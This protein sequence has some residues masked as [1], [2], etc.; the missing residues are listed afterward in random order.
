MVLGHT[1]ARDAT[2]GLRPGNGVTGRE[3]AASSARRLAPVF[4]LAAA[5]F[6]AGRLAL[7]LAIPPGYAT[8]VWPPAGIAL[9]GLLIVGRRAW[10]GVLLG[11]FL[12]NVWTGFDPTSPLTTVVSVAVPA[13]L[14]LGAALQAVV[15]ASLVRRVVGTPVTLVHAGDVI[16]FLSVAGPISCLVGASVGVT[17]LSVTGVVDW[18]N[19]LVNWS[20]W[21]AGDTIGALVFAPFVVLWSPQARVVP[22]RRLLVSLP[23][24]LA[25]AS[26]VAL[27]VQV[28][29]VE[30]A[31]IENAIAGRSMAVTQVIQ[32]DVDRSVEILYSIRSLYGSSVEVNQHEFGTFAGALLERDP[33]IL[34]LSWDRRVRLDERAGIETSAQTDT[35]GFQFTE[36]EADGRRVQAGVR[37]E[38]VPVTFIEPLIAN[39]EVLGFDVASDPA[40]LAALSKARDTGQEMASGATM[41]VQNGGN[42]R[43]FVVFLP[44]YANGRP[45]GSVEERRQNLVG[46]TAG[47]F[48][49]DGLIGA[50]I[51][52]ADRTELVIR[53]YDGAVIDQ[54]SLVYAAGSADPVDRAP[55]WVTSTINVAGRT[56]TVAVSPTS[57][58]LGAQP[59]GQPWFVLVGGLLLV[60]L[61]GA[62][63][64]I[65]TGR[66]DAI[67]NLVT[68]RTTQLSEANMALEREAG[69]RVRVEIA[70]RQMAS[71]VESSTDA[72]VG[73]G[74]DWAIVTWNASAT[75]LYGYTADE[76]AGRS[77][78]ILLP[79]DDDAALGETMERLRNA[80]SFPS[81]EAVHVR[82]DG[83]EV[84]VSVA[85]SGIRDQADRLAGISVIARDISEQ[86]AVD[87]MKD[88]FVS[89]VSHELRTPLT[90]IRASLGLLAGGVVED[91]ETS[92]R[93]FGIAVSNTDRLIRL[94]N[95]ILDAERLTSGQ[96]T[97]NQRGCDARELL[98]QAADVMRATA[99]VAGLRIVVEPGTAQMWADHDRI[100]QA[101]TNLLGNA[102]KFS[103]PGGTIRLGADQRDGHVIIHV[104][105][106]GRGIPAD[107]LERVFDRFSQVDA[108]DER[109][110]GGTG[111][112]L[113]I[114]RS[115]VE[116][117]GGRIWVESRP[118]VGSTFR[119]T[120]PASA[121]ASAMA[122]SSVR[123][124]AMRPG[125]SASVLT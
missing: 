65:A 16:R 53:I 58:F 31:R 70:L 34:A 116:Q 80:V 89:V 71:I 54:S 21:W 69:E 82:K 60:A 110:K 73:T 12:V 75:R 57:S 81:R 36:R 27:Y 56:W 85:F 4:A 87:R 98:A 79:P 113:A 112:G 120:V 90:A 50:A 125:E 62:F 39:A 24:L 101:V 97:L 84:Q 93:M 20:T 76:V 105:D 59:S 13:S 45:T 119:F 68:R 102:V 117:H 61:L 100:V 9:A 55:V 30:Q 3:R 17:T 35:P 123:D 29:S 86:K 121:T 33:G 108:S 40:R 1:I 37:P 67:A 66:A 19:Y 32:S 91:P 48:R 8:A 10:P 78:G 94:I 83:T 5:Y 63:L 26:V 11:S 64:L 96:V 103:P 41:L 122:S 43:G 28:S 38:Y 23:L 115:V 49:I 6:I 106:E 92:R 109:E 2:N 7:L 99:V 118:G 114:C 111:L 44:I 47:V 74:P 52:G 14:G 72:I 46:Y 15:G 42:E 88:E 124:R 107:M 77:I 22:W 18:S 25:F 95:D 51:V 104:T